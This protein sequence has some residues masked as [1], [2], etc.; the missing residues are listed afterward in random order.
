VKKKI[1][2]ASWIAFVAALGLGY[3][4]SSS[5]DPPS[6]V[7]QSFSLDGR[8]YTEKYTCNETFTGMPTECVDV[9]VSDVIVFTSTGGNNYTGEDV[10]DTGFVYTGTLNGTVLGARRARTATPNRGRGRSRPRGTASPDRR[11]TPPRKEPTPATAS[12]PESKGP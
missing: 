10:P 9:A 1:A 7:P 8:T 12:K 5:D 11:I 2:C 4:C 6:N 3:G